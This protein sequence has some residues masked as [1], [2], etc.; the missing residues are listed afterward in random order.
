MSNQNPIYSFYALPLFFFKN[1]DNNFILCVHEDSGFKPK[2]V[3][4]LETEF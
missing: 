4:F 1:L 3:T 2:P